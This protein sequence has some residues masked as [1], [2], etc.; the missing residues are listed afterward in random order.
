MNIHTKLAIGA[1]ALTV[2]LPGISIIGSTDAAA[3]HG[4]SPVH[5][6]L[7]RYER[8]H[9]RPATPATPAPA[10]GRRCAGG[11]PT[12]MGAYRTPNIPFSTGGAAAIRSALS[13]GHAT[14][15]H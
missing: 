11:C 8:Q 5:A 7:A 15:I 4:G 14:I 6:A 10:H 9:P 13:S 12:P 2:L 1:L 3:R